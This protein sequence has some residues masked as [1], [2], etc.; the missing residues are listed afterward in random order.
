MLWIPT[1]VVKCKQCDIFTSIQNHYH[2]TNCQ[3]ATDAKDDSG[4]WPMNNVLKTINRRQIKKK[5][6]WK[7]KVKA[8]LEHNGSL[9][10]YPLEV[11]KSC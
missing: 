1:K 3:K 2:Y 5:C 8:F 10:S 7:I 4:N 9:M 11:E 6:F